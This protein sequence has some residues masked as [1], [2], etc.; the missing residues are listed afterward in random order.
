MAGRG[1]SA[2][3]GGFDPLADRAADSGYAVDAG[4]HELSQRIDQLLISVE[5]LGSEG[6]WNYPAEPV[7][8]PAH[9]YP[10]TRYP[11]TPPE[12]SRNSYVYDA[13]YMPRLP[14]PAP[15][16]QP[17]EP[18]P[19]PW[20]AHE[21]AYAPPLPIEPYQPPPPAN[22]SAK[23]RATSTIPLIEITTLDAGS[24]ADLIELRHFEEDLSALAR[25]RDVRVRRFGR[26]RASIEIA[27]SSAT[28]LADELHLLAREMTIGTTPEAAEL[29]VE[30]VPLPPPEPDDES[31]DSLSKN[32][33]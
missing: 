6:R 22:G 17:F 31:G 32:E 27:V 24:F 26:G 18:S 10:T 12:P 25:V 29:V 16:E 23:E 20:R 3:P 4:L 2:Q 30:L 5:M 19:E 8:E 14:E 13:G 9:H 1:W 33:G 28:L 21:R 11:P 7:M 15:W